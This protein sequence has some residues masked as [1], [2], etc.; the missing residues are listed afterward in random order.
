MRSTSKTIVFF[1]N[2]RLSTGVTSEVA[3]LRSLIS[4]GYRIAAVVVNNTDSMQSRKPRPLEIAQIAAENRIPVLSPDSPLQIIDTLRS[5]NAIVGV[6][7]SY[8]KIIPQSVLNVFPCGI[9]NIHPSALP[10]YRGSTP[11]ES[12]ILNGDSETAVSIMRL[13]NKMDSG[14]IFAQQQYTLHIQG[15][16]KETIANDIL[17]LGAKLLIDT[18]PAI[19]GDS[20]EPIYQN[21]TQATY[22]RLIAKSDGVIDWHKDAERL[23]REVVA[24]AH[25]PRSSTSLGDKEVIITEAEATETNAIPGAMTVTNKTLEVGCASG[26]LRIHR[27]IPSGKKE[28]PIQ[29][30]LAGNKL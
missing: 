22:C 8:G 17:S 28:M 9:I 26:S 2:E 19:L 1:G 4:A 11:I 21:E 25:W 3:T 30:F 20:T 23:A 27:L 5:Y 16:S 29:A 13:T 10:L 15:S 7:V 14:P 6:L 12:A 18:L 24:Y